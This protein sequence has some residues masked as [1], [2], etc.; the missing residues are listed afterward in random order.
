[1]QASDR[2]QFVSVLLGLAAIKPGHKLTPEAFEIWWNAMSRDWSLDEF[3]QAASHLARSVEFMPS[4]YHFE[5][6]RLAANDCTADAAWEQIIT[7]HGY[8][9]DPVGARALH[10]L[11]GWKVVGFAETSRLPWLKERFREAYENFAD[12]AQAMESLPAIEPPAGRN[13]PRAISELLSR[14]PTILIEEGN[15]AP[16]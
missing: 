3:R 5:K 6:L 4:P 14:F 16:A 15:D 8:C 7:G 2:E 1:M 11:G 12:S 13:A 9:D 10:S